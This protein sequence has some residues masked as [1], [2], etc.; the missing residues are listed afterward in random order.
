[1]KKRDI[2]VLLGGLIIVIVLWMAPAETTKHLPQ[3]DT[4]QK[5]Y[6]MVQKDGTAGK[7]AAEKFC[8]NCHNP[9]QVPFPADHPPKLRCLFCHKLDK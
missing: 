6:A 3:N 4:H 1:M 9:D 5:F 8:Q 7:K 2:L